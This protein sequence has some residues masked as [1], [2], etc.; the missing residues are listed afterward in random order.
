MPMGLQSE[1]VLKIEKQIAWCEGVT[2]S[3]LDVTFKEVIVKSLY[4][5]EMLK[6]ERGYEEREQITPLKNVFV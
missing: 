5:N 1:E 6:K 2:D 3:G 4:A